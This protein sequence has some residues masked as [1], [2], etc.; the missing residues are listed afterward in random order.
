MHVNQ[1][2]FEYT[3][4]GGPRAHAE[5]P[6]SLLLEI[7]SVCAFP[8][9][10]HPIPFLQTPVLHFSCSEV[11]CI[12]AKV[13]EPDR[14]ASA[15]LSTLPLSVTV[16]LTKLFSLCLSFSNYKMRKIIA[17]H[18]ERYELNEKIWS[19]AHYL[20][21]SRCLVQADITDWNCPPGCHLSTWRPGCLTLGVVG[22]LGCSAGEATAELLFLL[23]ISSSPVASGSFSV[24]YSELLLFFQRRRWPQRS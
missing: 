6:P 7:I 3:V 5:G 4:S 23:A 22:T 10:S 1:T 2:H 16:I 24:T 18:S 12:R 13:L 21:P 15:W 17:P 9:P 20:V 14:Q 11:R 19:S 8:I